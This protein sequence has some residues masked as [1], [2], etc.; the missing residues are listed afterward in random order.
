MPAAERRTEAGEDERGEGMT[1]DEL[2]YIEEIRQRLGLS[3]HD[4][5]QDAVIENM[6]PWLRVRLIAGW[7]LGDEGWADTFRDYCQ[8]QGLYLTTN[9][10]ADG[11]LEG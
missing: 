2:G 8:S 10:D 7:Y 11:V 1:V 5:S 6:K 3:K 4:T 9:A